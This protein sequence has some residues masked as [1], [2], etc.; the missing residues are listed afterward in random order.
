MSKK[1][2]LVLLLGVLSLQNYGQSKQDYITGV[3]MYLQ[4]QYSKSVNY[5][6][7]YES[8]ASATELADICY[9]KGICEYYLFN[10]DESEKLLKKAYY[11][12]I[13]NPEMD[14]SFLEV[15]TLLRYQALC[16][17]RS[18]KENEEKETLYILAQAHNNKWAQQRIEERGF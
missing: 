9:I 7:K 1:L 15:T 12:Y 5:L 17:Q 4:G 2:I 3:S 18:G 14:F 16:L 13:D 6:T 11:F 8:H 10:Y